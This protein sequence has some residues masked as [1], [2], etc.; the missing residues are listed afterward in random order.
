MSIKHTFIGWCKEDTHDKV[1][2]VF[3]LRNGNGWDNDT[4]VTYW[5][6]RG[7]KLQTKISVSTEWD[8]EKL[9]ASKTHKGYVGIDEDKLDDVYPEFQQDLEKTAFWA[10]F[11]V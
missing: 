5:G 4:Y 3:K 10:M 11:K 7:K 2:G 1:W 6:R 8:I 9:I